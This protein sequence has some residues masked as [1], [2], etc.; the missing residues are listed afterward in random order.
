MKKTLPILVAVLTA[1]FILAALILR[2][3]LNGWLDVVLNWAVVTASAALLVAVA[4]LLLTHLRAILRGQRG[5]I[6]SIILISAFLV[7]FIG[8]LVLGLENSAY[9]R[10]V[11]AVQLPLETSLLGLA[12][13]VMTGA[14]LQIFRSRGWSLL[15]I[16]FGISA[17]V[18]L[19]ISLGL[20]QALNIPLLSTVIAYLQRLPLI[21]ARGLLIGIGIGALLTGLRV[22]FGLE[23]SWGE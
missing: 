7:S 11:A 6:Y 17:L 1:V 4:T 5:F 9:L 19:V 21:G 10:W 14:A 8:A 13:L 20:L 18:F 23:R 3:Q 2:P 22:L 16:S 12:A 15:T